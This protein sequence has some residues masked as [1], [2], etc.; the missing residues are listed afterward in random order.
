M[1]D[2]LGPPVGVAELQQLYRD[3]A[4][5][6]AKLQQLTCVLNGR[7][8]DRLEEGASIQRETRQLCVALAKQLKDHIR[9]EGRLA[10]R[11]SRLLGYLRL[12][13]LA[14]LALEHYVDQKHLSII[15][16]ALTHEGNG[17]L[18]HTA[19][20]LIGLIASMKRQMDVQEAD[21][22]PF[23]GRVFAVNSHSNGAV[24]MEGGNGMERAAQVRPVARQEPA[25][26]MANA[27]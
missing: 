26:S 18:S 24:R 8:P 23:L 6:R 10:I 13:E 9:K 3:H 1:D 2:R 4:E 19:P 21:L 16:R 11:C 7:P 14:W 12:E 15:S 17:C 25:V 27:P 5:I 20:L 22:Y